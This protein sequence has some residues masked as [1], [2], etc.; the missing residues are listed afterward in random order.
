VSQEQEVDREY[1]RWS[2]AFA[3]AE[4]FYGFDAGPVARRAVRYRRPPRRGGSTP[5]AL[6]LG[7][8]EGQDLAYF[9]EC[10]YN[11]TGVDFVENAL[12]KSRNLLGLR[13]LSGQTEYSDL[14]E[15]RAAQTYDLVLACN[16]LQ[17][18]GDDAPLV[19]ERVRDAVATGGVLGLSLFGCENGDEVRAGVYSSSLETLLARF[20]HRGE[21]RSWQILESAKLWQW[22][23]TTNAPQSFVTLI[24]ARLK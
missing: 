7:C 1:A 24:A 19:L 23:Q 2:A 6:D 21:N 15:W 22:N 8:G 11:A 17:F 4:Y 14:R 20:D 12:Q 5:S 18:L 10:G 16:S 3:G 9:A 13:G